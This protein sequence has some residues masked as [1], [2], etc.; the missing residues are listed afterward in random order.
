MKLIYVKS[1]MEPKNYAVLRSLLKQERGEKI[2]PYI[3]KL[4]NPNPVKSYL[5]KEGI[6]YEV[7]YEDKNE[8]EIW[9]KDILRANQDEQRNKEISEWNKIS[10][11]RDKQDW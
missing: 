4:E 1:T 7:Y 11:V 6:T 9:K 8:E 10:K 3:F 2:A 5:Q